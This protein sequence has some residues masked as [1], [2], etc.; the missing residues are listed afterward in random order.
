MN[1]DQKGVSELQPI[2]VEVERL[3]VDCNSHLD[4]NKGANIGRGCLN[5]TFSGA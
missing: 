2:V 1:R 3:L 5:Q 4:I